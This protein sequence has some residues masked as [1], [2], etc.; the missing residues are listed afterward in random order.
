MKA[1]Q[2]SSGRIVRIGTGMSFIWLAAAVT[3]IWQAQASG[4]LH[5]SCATGPQ[6]FHARAN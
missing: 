4:I 1:Q 5:N 3:L 6:M 2:T